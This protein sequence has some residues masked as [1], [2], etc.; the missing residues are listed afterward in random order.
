MYH[1]ELVLN[2]CWCTGVAGVEL[3]EAV[4][5]EGVEALEAVEGAE[6]VAVGIRHLPFDLTF[7]NLTHCQGVAKG[8]SESRFVIHCCDADFGTCRSV[9]QQYDQKI[10]KLVLFVNPC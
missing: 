5:G 8:T 4:E 10:A 7:D 3:M 9:N 2:R 1:F 6:A